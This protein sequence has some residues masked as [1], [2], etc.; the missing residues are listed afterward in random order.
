M[1]TNIILLLCSFYCSIHQMEFQHK[2]CVNPFSDTDGHYILPI[3]LRCFL[4]PQNSFEDRIFNIVYLISFLVYMRKKWASIFS[5]DPSLAPTLPENNKKSS[6]LKSSHMYSTQIGS[7]WGK[8]QLAWS[9]D[10]QNFSLLHHIHFL[11][12]RLPSQYQLEYTSVTYWHPL[13]H[14]LQ[15]SRVV[16]LN[17]WKKNQNGSPISLI[18]GWSFDCCM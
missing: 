13:F 5:G 10:A 7:P 9:Q 15:G 3:L 2:Q 14:H 16:Q 8:A 1:A 11:G 6:D 4:Q 12:L 18:V 17:R